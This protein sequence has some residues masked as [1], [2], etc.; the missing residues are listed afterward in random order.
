MPPSG[1]RAFTDTGQHQCVYR[2]TAGAQRGHRK[3]LGSRPMTYRRRFFWVPKKTRDHLPPCESPSDSKL[4]Q[5]DAE[6]CGMSIR[7]QRDNLETK[8][9]CASALVT[10]MPLNSLDLPEENRW[11]SHAKHFKTTKSRYTLNNLAL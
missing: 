3:A 9:S 4:L 6:V 8:R 1:P 11:S 10:E 7:V 5:F 2:Y